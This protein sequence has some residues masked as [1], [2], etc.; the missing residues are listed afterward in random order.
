MVIFIQPNLIWKIFCKAS[1]G[2]MCQSDKR[3]QGNSLKGEFWL[4]L[5]AFETCVDVWNIK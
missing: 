4:E 2:G 3:L 5:I 1:S